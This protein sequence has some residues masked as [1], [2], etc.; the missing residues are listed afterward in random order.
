MLQEKSKLQLKTTACD[1]H[2]ITELNFLLPLTIIKTKRKSK[3]M[4]EWIS[5]S[6]PQAISDSEH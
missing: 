6:E 3:Y 2:E 5:E 1:Q 4:K